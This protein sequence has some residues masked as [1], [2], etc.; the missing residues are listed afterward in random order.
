MRLKRHFIILFTLIVISINPLQSELCNLTTN[1]YTHNVEN[2][3]GIVLKFGVIIKVEAG[4]FTDAWISSTYRE[5]TEIDN[6]TFYYMGKQYTRL[7]YPALFENYYPKMKWVSYSFN[8]HFS[9][10]NKTLRISNVIVNDGGSNLVEYASDVEVKAFKKSNP[11]FEVKQ[12]QFSHSGLTLGSF[13]LEGMGEIISKIE[14]MLSS[15]KHYQ[16]ALTKFNS[17]K[18]QEALNSIGLAEDF[19]YG[20]PE[21]TALKEKVEN[22]LKTNKTAEVKTQLESIYKSA[23]NNF[24]QKN[25]T[26]AESDINRAKGLMIKN[27]IED[28]RFESLQS[29]IDVA[30]K[31]AEKTSE[32]S[33]TNETATDSSSSTANSTSSSSSSQTSSSNTPEVSEEEAEAARKKAQEEADAKAEAERKQRVQE[34]NERVSNQNASNDA[35]A[36]QLLLYTVLVHAKIGQF[37]YQDL[38]LND[39]N[40][41]DHPGHSLE[42]NVGYSFTSTPVYANIT[43][44]SYNGNTYR[45]IETIDT[46]TPLSLNLNAGLTF[47]HLKYKYAGIGY[48]VSAGAGHGLYLQNFHLNGFAGL[49]AYL[50][51]PKL[52]AYTEYLAGFRDIK[53]NEWTN[54]QKVQKGSAN[55]KFHQF[56]LGIR[57]SD[58]IY[59]N[60]ETVLNFDFLPMFELHHNTQM[61]PNGS[62]PIG[63]NWSKGF[64]TG[65]KFDNRLSIMIQ[66]LFEYPIQGKDL[67]PVTFNEKST[68]TFFS[69]SVLRNIE[70]YQ[71]QKHN[72]T[73]YVLS[74]LA[75]AHKRKFSE[76]IYFS[77]KIEYLSVGRKIV[78]GRVALKSMKLF[79]Y[80]ANSPITK[81]LAVNWGGGFSFHSL[82]FTV[83]DKS[84]FKNGLKDLTS[85][86]FDG[87]NFAVPIGLKLHHDLGGDKKYWILAG[88]EGRYTKLTSQLFKKSDIPN[89]EWENAESDF[90]ANLNGIYW[91]TGCGMNYSIAG[92]CFTTGLIY[93]RA[94]K[95][96]FE[97]DNAR[98]QGLEFRFGR[99]L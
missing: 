74:D 47:W 73:K 75:N 69:I 65:V 41:I 12:S 25:Y 11:A 66:C 15:N 46:E 2:R 99:I 96:L 77:P 29:K 1:W 18:Y 9:P 49:K 5:C 34:Y 92:K 37:I 67:K 20:S 22:A 80:L 35:A 91:Q 87:L 56:K 79:S 89:S 6:S 28:T 21:L 45:Y 39:G 50:G 58:L 70:Y 8:T 38:D 95:P 53:Y 7:Q 64:E 17:Q 14:K 86:K 82:N 32:N 88:I 31:E 19:G 62:N 81:Y 90:K 43:T 36:I 57:I 27:E 48:T 4:G 44:E 26:S 3:Y 85:Y 33:S 94:I 71:N 51:H 78:N 97:G 42:F 24:N 30:K 55:Y 60:G 72:P 10:N 93:T 16:D 84:S 83:R 68:G 23:E 59:W 40:D 13:S 52:K 98:I 54:A 76:L 63:F 61:I